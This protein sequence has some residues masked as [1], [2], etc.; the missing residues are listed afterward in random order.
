MK[1]LIAKRK[2]SNDCIYCNRAIE[3]GNVY[4]FERKVVAEDGKVYSYQ[5]KTCAKCKYKQDQHNKRYERYTETCN[6]PRKFIETVWSYIPGECVKQPDYDICRL[7][8]S[9]V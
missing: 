8:G 2:H 7:C 4:Y 1:R 5:Y 6:H 3:K 9:I